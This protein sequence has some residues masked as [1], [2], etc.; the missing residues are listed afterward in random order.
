MYKLIIKFAVIYTSP[1]VNITPEYLKHN[2]ILNLQNENQIKLNE[3]QS[4]PPYVNIT[5]AYLKFNPITNS[6]NMSHIYVNLQDPLIKS[7][8]VYVNI[9][10][11]YV[12][13]NPIL[14]SPNMKLLK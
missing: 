4:N 8:P 5:A 1:Y 7:N 13:Y 11:Q 9:T 14:N 12:K 3:T 2:S 10:S 6:P